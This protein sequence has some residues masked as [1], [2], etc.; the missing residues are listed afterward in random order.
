MGVRTIIRN[1][2]ISE[3][4]EQGNIWRILR[5]KSIVD[6][7]GLSFLKFQKSQDSIYLI[8]IINYSLKAKIASRLRPLTQTTTGS[9]L[10]EQFKSEES[11]IYKIYDDLL[12]NA[13]QRLDICADDPSNLNDEIGYFKVINQ[14]E[15]SVFSDEVFDH[16]ICISLK[17]LTAIEE[18]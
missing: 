12:K 13:T 2:F 15:N 9:E 1:K 16:L 4:T 14:L 11:E 17:K 10:L 8:D 7:I 18:P 6:L 5:T 3:I